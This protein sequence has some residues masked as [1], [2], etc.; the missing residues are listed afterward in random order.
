MRKEVK[1]KREVLLEKIAARAWTLLK[2]DKEYFAAY[3]NWRH[4]YPLVDMQNNPKIRE[5]FQKEGRK[6]RANIKISRKELEG[7]LFM[8]WELHGGPKDD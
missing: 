7:Y 4:K 5:E 3:A 2:G 1:T 8:L 6:I